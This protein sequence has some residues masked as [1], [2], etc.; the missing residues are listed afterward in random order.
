M[1]LE[2]YPFVECLI[3][4]LKQFKLDYFSTRK[5]RFGH[6]GKGSFIAS[7]SAVGGR[8]NIFLDDYVNI[9]G[10][11]ILYTTGCKFIMKK[12]SGAA[13]GLTVITGN[14]LTE[15]GECLKDRGNL[16]LVH[17]DIIVEEEVWIAANVTLLAGTHIGRGAII[18]AGSVLRGSKVPPYAI[19]AGNPA[20]II[21]FRF[22]VEE[23]IQHEEI[24]YQQDER[25]PIDLLIKNYKKYFLDRINEI[26]EFNRL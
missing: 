9:D 10:N 11:N 3:T 2:K 19:V 26:K 23:I 8:E 17:K 24:R 6:L 20:K 4:G 18:G 25:L 16:N 5:D 15:V 7:P 22:T 14:H 13:R 21:G 12:Y 1:K